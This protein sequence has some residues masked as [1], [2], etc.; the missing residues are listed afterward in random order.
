MVSFSTDRAADR[1]MGRLIGAGARVKV[2]IFKADWVFQPE[3]FEG[4]EMKL[5]VLGASGPIISEE[6]DT[7]PTAARDKLFVQA[8]PAVVARDPKVC[9]D[10]Q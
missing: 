1:A 9:S 5:K 4:T 6:I 7:T 8:K 3:M 2:V 10:A